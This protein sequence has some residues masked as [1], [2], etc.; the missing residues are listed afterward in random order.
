MGSIGFRVTNDDQSKDI[1]Y[2]TDVTIEYE[3]FL[4]DIPKY[5][6]SEVDLFA[7]I[8]LGYVCSADIGFIAVFK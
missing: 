2:T 7:F 8:Y 6:Y 5:S 1:F 3:Y 4:I